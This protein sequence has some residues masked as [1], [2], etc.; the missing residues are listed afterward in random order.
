MRQATGFRSLRLIATLAAVA[1]VASG[2]AAPRDPFTEPPRAIATWTPAPRPTLAP[3]ELAPLTGTRVALGSVAG[4]SIAA[5]IDNHQLARPQAGLEST[6]IVFEEL[7]E[8]G[9]TRYVAI[10]HSNIPETIGPVRSIRPMDPFIVAPFGGIIAYSG[11]QERFVS[12]MRNT[13]VY[14]AIHGQSDTS[15][16]FFRSKTRPGPHDVLVSAQQVVQQ[17]AGIAPPIQQFQHATGDQWSSAAAK[18]EKALSASFSFSRGSER[19]WVWSESQRRWLR[20]MDGAV[21]VDGNGNQ[22]TA[23]NLVVLRVRVVNDQGVPRTEMVDSGEAWVLS[24][25]KTLHGVWSKTEKT[26]II[27]LTGDDGEPILLVP[28]NTWV[29]LVP[30]AGSVSFV[31]PEPPVIP[32]PLPT[33]PGNLR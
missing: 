1:L 11:G 30:T 17:H 16:T 4:P 3:Y 6:D 21:H 28:G 33:A 32:T 20:S 24:D 10:W 13:P 9:L 5:K 26:A 15:K 22:L 2:C 27:T 14:N 19:G 31:R 29:E 23:S 8:G 25:G 7:V 12:Q 18:G